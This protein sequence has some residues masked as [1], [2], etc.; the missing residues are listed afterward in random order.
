MTALR[1]ETAIRRNIIILTDFCKLHL[2]AV[3]LR[4]C[5][6][7]LRLS[8]QEYD[9]W[10]RFY[11]PVH[12]RASRSLVVWRSLAHSC[13]FKWLF[14]TTFFFKLPQ[15]LSFGCVAVSA[16][17]A[18]RFGVRCHIEAARPPHAFQILPAPS[19]PTFWLPYLWECVIRIVLEKLEYQNCHCSNYF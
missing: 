1:W 5:E 18:D 9:T 4:A 15:L 10:T 6:A 8:V 17:S 7:S 13:V 16:R 12:Y 3:G 11:H 2:L 14:Q 19:A